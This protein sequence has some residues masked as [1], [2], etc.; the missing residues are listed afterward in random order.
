MCSRIGTLNPQ[1]IEMFGR[2]SGKA[3]SCPDD[4]QGQYG[5]VVEG[6]EEL[7]KAVVLDS[8]IV[9]NSLEGKKIAES[10][11]EPVKTR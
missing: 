3:E 2:K 6:R 7:D 11:A 10:V 5:G 1:N 4:G 8:Q 9:S